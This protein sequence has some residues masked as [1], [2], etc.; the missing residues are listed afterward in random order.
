MNELSFITMIAVSSNS[1]CLLMSNSYKNT[2]SFG[3]TWIGGASMKLVYCVF[4]WWKVS[5]KVVPLWGRRKRDGE[6]ERERV[7]VKYSLFVW[8]AFVWKV[9]D[10]AS[11]LNNN[12]D[13]YTHKQY[14]MEDGDG[15]VCSPRMLVNRA[16][17]LPVMLCTNTE[18]WVQSLMMWTHD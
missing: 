12:N 4:M 6:R 15:V 18:Y 8:P 9:S 17:P 13:V 7:T 1:H 14:C 5:V 10:G 2:F 3:N 11:P 16:L